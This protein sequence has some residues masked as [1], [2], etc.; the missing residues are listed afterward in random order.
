MVKC[1]LG[2]LQA[3]QIVEGYDL[4]Y[5]QYNDYM[6]HY[7]GVQEIILVRKGK[8]PEKKR[9]RQEKVKRL[10]DEGIL[11]EGDDKKKKVKWMRT[12]SSKSS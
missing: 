7:P 5:L 10:S 4:R 11:V 2:E 1:H 6:N 3:G 8:D 9:K 12:R